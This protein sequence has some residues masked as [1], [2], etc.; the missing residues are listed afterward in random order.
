MEIHLLHSNDVHSHLENHMKLGHSL[1]QLRD[2]LRGAGHAVLTFDI[3]DAIDRVRPETEATMG[4]INA[5]MMAALGYDGWVFG[6]NEG[7]TIP[8]AH[9]QTLR[10]RAETTVFGTNLRSAGA[11]IPGFVDWKVFTFGDVRV[12]VFGVTA[13]YDKP[14]EHLAVTALPPFP[15]AS[16]AVAALRAQGCHVI[17]ALSHLG[18][19]DD[20]KMAAAV[21][22]IDVI[23]GGH[24]HTWME[25]PEFIG[26]TAVF[27]VGLHGQAFGHTILKLHPHT[28]RV[29]G[30]AARTIP[31]E[32][33]QPL[34]TA[35]LSAYR[36]YLPA[37]RRR[38]SDAVTRLARPLPVWFEEESPF[39]N[40][41]AD[42]LLTAFPCDGAIMMAG[43]LNAS[44]LA[45]IITR[46]DVLAACST[47]TRPL[48]MNLR[49]EDLWEI[50][51]KSL[52]REYFAAR[53]K[54][55][56]FRGSLVGRLALSGLR[57]TLT[58][59]ETGM[60][61]SRNE[62]ALS[63]LSIGGQPVVPEAVYRIVTCEYLWLSPL[64]PEFRRGWDIDIRPL[65]VR[66]VLT[67]HLRNGVC[68]A[69]AYERRYHVIS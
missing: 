47:P 29:T 20:R 57:A 55:F 24:S 15:Q 27:Q 45:G 30:V 69:G 62:Y 63:A 23:L 5:A 18:I 33:H 59:A 42:A 25:G 13:R 66:E 67:D 17:V 37:V 68:V 12:G 3:G 26:N 52:Q 49:G 14:Y 51:A 44:L 7:L 35:M 40:L 38:L 21:P 36:G 64:Y 11:P 46:G 16:Q 50:V 22:G 60:R 8:Y 54:G 19:W 9:W 4:E 58:Q 48:L 39:A 32:T 56:G 2:T 31:T 41:L 28:R 53:G 43:A 10:E 65:L 34:D 1:R 6:N 61:A